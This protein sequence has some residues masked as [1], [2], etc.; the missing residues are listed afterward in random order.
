M[1]SEESFKSVWSITK[2]SLAPVFSQGRD[3][4]YSY[5]VETSNDKRWAQF[6]LKIVTNSKLSTRTLFR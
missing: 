5:K 4:K 3:F 2:G 1:M 6:K